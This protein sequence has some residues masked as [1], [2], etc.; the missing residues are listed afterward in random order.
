MKLNDITCKLIAD[1]EYIIG[2]E[3]YN[4]H[5]Y[6]GWNDIEGCDFRYPVNV[7]T[8]EGNYGRVRGNINDSYYSQVVNSKTIPFIKYKF[9]ANELFIGR[10]IINLL[11]YLEERYH[12]S[13]SDM[14]AQMEKD[15]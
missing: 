12:I 6:D 11:E 4:P 3:C 9:G 15:S 1:L 2:S 13:F 14:E 5:S 8:E 7:P 10:G